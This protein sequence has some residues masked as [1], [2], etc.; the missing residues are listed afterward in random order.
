MA[1]PTTLL[2]MPFGSNFSLTALKRAMCYNTLLAT[3]NFYIKQR[4]T[5]TYIG[6]NVLRGLGKDL[7]GILGPVRAAGELVNENLGKVVI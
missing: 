1:S 7:A 3:S 4:G 5:K 2:N 6:V